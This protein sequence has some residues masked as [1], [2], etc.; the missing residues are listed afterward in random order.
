VEP[1]QRAGSEPISRVLVVDD[2]ED[3]LESMRILLERAGYQ[4]EVASNGAQAVLVQRERPAHVL[5]TDIFMPEKNGIELIDHFK[6]EFPEVR[7]IAMSGGGELVK[8]DYLDR[9]ELFGADSTL[10]K[11]FEPENLREALRRVLST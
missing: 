3:M 6:Q 2:N 10:R 11:P 4:V 5:I 1:Q 8:R 9:T 7:I